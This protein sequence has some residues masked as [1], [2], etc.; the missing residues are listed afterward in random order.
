MTVS[1][2][3]G[4]SPISS[5]DANFL[6][7][8]ASKGEKAN[9]QDLKSL[10]IQA[11][12]GS[13][14]IEGDI[15]KLASSVK[16]NAKANT[17][18]SLDKQIQGSIIALTILK[19]NSFNPFRRNEL[20]SQIAELQN[21]AKAPTDLA[22]SK[23]K[24]NVKAELAKPEN[25]QQLEYYKDALVSNEYLRLLKDPDLHDSLDAYPGLVKLYNL[26]QLS[27]VLNDPQTA[28]D[29]KLIQDLYGNKRPISDSILKGL[30]EVRALNPKQFTE[31]FKA[32]EQSR[33]QTLNKLENGRLP[34]KDNPNTDPVHEKAD[35]ASEKFRSL[36][37]RNKELKNFHQDL[38]MRCRPQN[39]QRHH[40][41]IMFAV[42]PN[43]DKGKRSKDAKEG[44]NERLKEDIKDGKELLEDLKNSPKTPENIEKEKQVK[45]I[46]NELESLANFYPEDSANFSQ[47]IE[48]VPVENGVW[49]RVIAFRSGDEKTKE[50]PVRLDLSKFQDLDQKEIFKFLQEANR[51]PEWT[52]QYEREG[53]SALPTES[54]AA[55]DRINGLT[56]DRKEELIA[57]ARDFTHAVN[58]DFYQ[59]FFTLGT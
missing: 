46:L 35:Q 14:D 20:Q 28:V 7:A 50:T 27:K 3:A 48:W 13:K 45:E 55:L 30:V 57:I 59:K 21:L 29:L 52:E 53:S 2:G 44:A 11:H 51:Y 37:I 47:K 4:S 38:F 23:L 22:L 1:N 40:D 58:I 10:F 19:N 26:T 9:I 15:S 16:T 8:V 34:P 5:P 12:S 56:D 49:D 18:R 41:T 42:D 54:R 43:D 17:N 36:V 32:Y 31:V 39:T 25:K 33:E 6:E 24:A